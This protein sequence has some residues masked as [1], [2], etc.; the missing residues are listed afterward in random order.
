MNT[1]P[2]FRKYGK[3]PFR[4]LLVHGGPGAT[5]DLERLAQHLS[6]E[7]GIIESLHRKKNVEGQIQ[8][9][10]SIIEENCRQAIVLVGHSW[11]A[12]LSYMFTAR[13]PKLIEKLIMISSGPLEGDY[14]SIIAATRLGRMDKDQLRLNMQ[15]QKQLKAKDC[16]DKNEIFS[17]IGALIQRLD[18]YQIDPGF[19]FSTTC[20][21]EI[22]QG[23]YPEAYEIRNNG[24]LLALGEF[25]KCPVVAIQGAYD[26]HPPEGV[27]KPL[28]N[29]LSNFQF[30]VLEKCGHYPWLEMQARDGFYQILK[31]GLS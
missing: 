27:K 10:K 31:Q 22:Y 25:I 26:P 24:K 20:H 11:G 17:K 5:G 18:S 19:A 3:G 21:F 1:A 8:E 29:I 4:V 23:V 13:Y 9:L 2:T 7:T 14:T 12:W 30:H 15:L 28:K 6:P 16:T